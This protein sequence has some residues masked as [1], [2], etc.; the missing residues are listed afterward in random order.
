[1]VCDS[2]KIF[3]PGQTIMQ[4]QNISFAYGRK[5][6]LRD[7]SLN[8]TAGKLLGLLG[9]N[10][11]GKTTLFKCCL[12]FLKIS[13]GQII[14]GDKSLSSYSA[15]HLAAHVAYVPQEHKPAFPFLVREMVEM[16]RTPHR[17]ALPVLSKSDHRAVDHALDRVGLKDLAGENFNHLSGGQRQLVLVARALAQEASLMF[18]DEPTSS[19]DFSNQ[20][21]VWETVRDIAAEGLGVVICCHDPNH[22]LWFCDEVAA[23]KEGR[24]LAVGP[25]QSTITKSLLEQLYERHINTAEVGSRMF[26]YP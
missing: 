9:P 22:I 19:L 6:V 17:G 24:L 15:R 18:L 8:I 1:M 4:V 21:T 10:G 3:Q 11:S 12:G 7:I 5:E 20:L 26:I 13:S 2:H 25:A 14:L 23:L 16:G